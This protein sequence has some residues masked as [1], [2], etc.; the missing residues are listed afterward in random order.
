[1]REIFFSKFFSRNWT[2]EK[3]DVRC[4]KNCT[5]PS[6]TINDMEFDVSYTVNPMKLETIVA[7]LK[8]DNEVA[9]T[10]SETRKEEE[11]LLEEV[12][13]GSGEHLLIN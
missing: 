8:K 4:D 9:N 10:L 5:E 6:K 1:M 7:M 3:C 13:E 11:Q 2:G 12:M